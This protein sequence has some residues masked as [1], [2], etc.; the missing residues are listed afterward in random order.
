MRAKGNKL[1]DYLSRMG[2]TL[3]RY[4]LC[5]ALLTANAFSPASFASD[6]Q[7]DTLIRNGIIYDGSGGPPY[8][9]EVAIDGDHIA[10]VGR[11]VE[12]HARNDIDARGEAI[13]PGFIN[14]LSHSEDSLLEDGR[15]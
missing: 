6:P 10:A 1:M 15:G 2:S 5:I 9:G 14:M 3:R 7:H 8:P 12:G 13:A 11:H 4:T